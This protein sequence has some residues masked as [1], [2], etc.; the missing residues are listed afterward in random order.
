[1]YFGVDFDGTVARQT[2]QT[3]GF[4]LRPG[5]ADALRS[6]KNAGHV[7]LLFS[8]RANRALR[9]D[10]MLDPLVRSG[11]RRINREQWEKEQPLHQKRYAQMIEF[12]EKTLPDVFSAIDDGMQGKPVVDLFIDDKVL[13]LEA[14][15]QFSSWRQIADL[16]GV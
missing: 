13:N 3:G 5:A 8:A 12:V 10:P 7:L 14:D 2:G 1:M 6:L 9:E 11:V 16:Y 4:K 15:R